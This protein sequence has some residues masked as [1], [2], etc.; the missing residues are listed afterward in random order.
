M[1]LNIKNKR[2]K[3][4]LK[5]QQEEG[6][7]DKYKAGFTTED[8]SA[9]KFAVLPPLVSNSILDEDGEETQEFAVQY[10]LYQG[11]DAQAPDWHGNMVP[12]ANPENNPYVGIQSFKDQLNSV[13]K[14]RKENDKVDEV[15]LYR[16]DQDDPV[17]LL[18]DGEDP[19]IWG[20]S[21][22]VTE[23]LQSIDDNRKLFKTRYIFPVVPLAFKKGI[24]G[25]ESIEPDEWE[26]YSKTDKKPKLLDLPEFSA[27][28]LL[29]KIEQ[30]Y[31]K[32]TKKGHDMYD[33]DAQ[34]F[35]V[36]FR[37]KN[38]K[39]F[40]EYSFDF[41]METL[42]TDDRVPLS[43]GVKKAIAKHYQEGERGDPM[44]SLVYK[45]ASPAQLL[46]LLGATDIDDDDDEPAP[47]KASK[48][49][50]A[51]SCFGTSDYDT[52]DEECSEECAFFEACG[53]AQPKD[54]EPEVDE[55]EDDDVPES[56]DDEDEED[57]E[58]EPAPKKAKKKSAALDALRKKVNKSMGDD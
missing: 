52:E 2:V 33:E 13:N 28:G 5:K 47:K 9:Y 51:P 45:Y 46:G 42:D 17:A 7:G 16:D 8:G 6:S 29:E 34:T 58:P 48:P 30:M 31:M 18:L 54:D 24:T 43:T 1:A 21:V 49:A 41:D 32:R 22:D 40:T 53:K 55:L 38:K 19:S 35:F 3:T 56:W 39:N 57:E 44:R 27:K 50:K 37:Y 14:W 15:S 23:R 12:V 11:L 10:T 20:L 25:P 36:M 26:A 4:R